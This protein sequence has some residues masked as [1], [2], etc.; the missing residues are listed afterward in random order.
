MKNLFALL[1]LVLTVNTAWSQQTALPVFFYC[2]SQKFANNWIDERQKAGNPMNEKEMEFTRRMSYYAQQRMFS[3]LVRYNDS[4]TL[5]IRKI[6][7]VIL[8]H[9]TAL[10]SKVSFFVFDD[11]DPNAFASATG[12]IMVTTGLIAQ[13]ENEAQLAF[14]LC[15]EVTHFK[16]EHMLKGFLTR[17]D[18]R[19]DKKAPYVPVTNYYTYNKEQ[20]LEAD[21]MG[22]EL[23]RKTKYSAKE[24]LRSFDI[25]EYSDLPFDD[26]PFDTLFFNR[27]YMVVPPGYYVKTT[28]PIYSDDNY[29][30]R[31]ST[32]PNIRK[33]RMA[34]MELVDSTSEVG[35][36]QFIVSN[37]EFSNVR[38]QAR[39]ELCRL[40]LME[41]RYGD[42]IYTAYL[43]QKRHPQERYFNYV[44]AYSLYNM[45][46]YKQEK[47]GYYNP[48]MYGYS[49]S[50]I[51]ALNAKGSYRFPTPKGRPGEQQQVYSLF[52]SVEADELTAL[53]LA[54][55]WDLYKSNPSDSVQ[56]KL[57]DSL[58]SM[59]VN[60]QNL[61]R[62]YFSV[63]TPEQTREQLKQDS[64]KRVA[65]V[66]ELGESKYS[67]LEKFRLDSPKERYVKFA[68][69]DQLKDS[70]FVQRFDYHIKHRRPLAGD[71]L[72][73]IPRLSKKEREAKREEEKKWGHDITKVLVIAPAYT[74]LKQVK[75]GERSEM[76]YE[77]SEKGQINVIGNVNS[78]ATSAG[79][80]YKMLNPLSMDST[81]VDSFADYAAI[82]RWMNEQMI[83]GQHG[84][85]YTLNN[86]QTVDS[87]ST[88]YGVRYV[89]L[90]DVT[91]DKRKKIQR[92]VLYG[93]SC[94]FVFPLYKLF[95][96]QDQLT[97]ESA[98]VDLKTGNVVEYKRTRAKGRKLNAKMQEH[99]NELFAKMSKPVKPKKTE[100]KSK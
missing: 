83:H 63:I 73:E 80:K 82:N 66:G 21:K 11:P 37:K 92:P 75:R 52:S 65:E 50:K 49:G 69:V 2:P 38:E 7:N 13:A 97:I 22:F 16:M 78:A 17:E 86:R 14:I 100:E 85:A 64:L 88:T 70:L 32:H 60:K 30:D 56:F 12:N 6:A 89:V 91:V 68:F 48:W 42:A 4:M 46:A 90:T 95:K 3:G 43:M 33:R 47:S 29:E 36:V 15:H 51:S 99:Y 67:K 41:L 18:R 77:E 9:D 96:V 61:H 79:V 84:Y 31:N 53:A 62:S 20:E 19:N 34:L 10:K 59:L 23:F 1:S 28:D 5:Y 94:V 81:D 87:I 76:Q 24:A 72:D 27:G 55:N 25:L 44:I 74:E 54:Y 45:A 40:Y 98:V 93:M 71:Q 8:E 26:V 57:C 39:Y 35:R 58:F